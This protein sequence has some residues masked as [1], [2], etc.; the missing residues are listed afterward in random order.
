RFK[1]A[2]FGDC[3]KDGKPVYFSGDAAV[4]DENG[5]ITITGR[6][7]K[8]LILMAVCLTRKSMAKWSVGIPL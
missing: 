5:Y 3:T 1:K 2:Y 7:M 4:V 8:P 6:T